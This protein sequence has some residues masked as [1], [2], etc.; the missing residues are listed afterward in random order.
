MSLLAFYVACCDQCE[1]DTGDSRP[2][3]EEAIDYAIRG[4]WVHRDEGLFCEE[5]NDDLFGEE[6]D[7]S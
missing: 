5:C 2:N 6:S 7:E 3:V 4:G 1:M